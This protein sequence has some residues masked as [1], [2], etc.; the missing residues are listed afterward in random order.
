M[1]SLLSLPDFGLLVIVIMVDCFLKN[2][3]KNI[4]K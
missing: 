2:S 3:F 1:N 4:L